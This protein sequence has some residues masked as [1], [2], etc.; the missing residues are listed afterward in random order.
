MTRVR[1]E[2]VAAMVDN[3]ML[4][5]CAASFY[6]FYSL[7]GGYA[8]MLKMSVTVCTVCTV[9]TVVSRSSCPDFRTVSVFC[10]LFR[11]YVRSKDGVARR[12]VKECVEKRVEK[13]WKPFTRSSNE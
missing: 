13:E 2:A 10:S 11:L 6:S 4:A 3:F 1:K 8:V 12:L 5:K 9:C 7:M